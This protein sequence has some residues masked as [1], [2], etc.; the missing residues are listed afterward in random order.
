MEEGPS[1]DDIARFSDEAMTCPE[2]GSEV[3][4]DSPLCQTCGHAFTNESI[5]GRK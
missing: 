5:F 3:Y 4:H 1:E 2:C